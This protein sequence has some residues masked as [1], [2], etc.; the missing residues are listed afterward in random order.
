MRDKRV[1]KMSAIRKAATLRELGR[2]ALALVTLALLTGGSLWL[3]FPL[4]TT[5]F[6][7]L[8]VI[9]LVS[10]AGSFITSVAL[11]LFAVGCLDFFFTA[12]VYSFRIDDPQQA[13]RIAAFFVTSLVIAGLVKRVDARRAE[14]AD[15]ARELNERDAKIKRL[16]DSNIVGIFTWQLE[17][18][19]IRGPILEAN[20]AFLRM[21]GYAR[22]DFF[23]RRLSRMEL[24]PPEW[25]A[26]SEQAMAELWATGAFQLYEKEYFRKD[27]GRVPVLV[28]A[29]LFEGAEKQGMAF[30]LDLTERKRVERAL[31]ESEERFRVLSESSVTGIYLIQDGLF[32][33]INPAAAKM[34]GYTVEEL[35]D[36]LGP[37]DVVCPEDRIR[38]AENFR[39]RSERE[40]Q[41]VRHAFRGL[42]KDG[43][44]FPVEVHGRWIDH[45]GKMAVIGTITD[46][47]ERWKAEQ[48][49][50]ESEAKLERA[51]E[52]AHFGW[53]E[54]DLKTKRV[55]LSD[56]V[57]RIFGLRPVD[58]PEWHGRW[59]TLI[60]PEDR[61]RAEKAAAAAL[62]P[63]GPR[64]DVEYRVVRRDGTE[65][66][67]HSQGDVTWDENGQPLRQFGVLQDITD[68]RRAEDE[69]R[70]SEER[71]RTIV[72]YAS[73]AFFVFDGNSTVLDVNREA[74][75]SLGY[76][77]E[78]L[79][80][81]HRSDF[82]AAL[83]E[84][85]IQRLKHRLVSGEPITFE[86]RH[87]RKDGTTFP[88]EVRV[89]DF[90]QGGER[91]FLCLVRDITERKRAEERLRRNETYLAAA[92][93]LSKMGS[94][95]WRPA[96]NEITHWSQG[97]YRLFG[98]DPADGVP[99]LE[100]VLDRI[101]PE[102]RALWLESRSLVA[103][104]E[105]SDFD[106]RIVLPDGGTKHVHAVG[107]PILNESGEVVEVMGAAADIS[108][109]KRAE[110]ELRES[111]ARFRSFVDHASDGFFLFDEGQ[112]LID[113][114][115][116]AC[117]SLGYTRDE[118]IGMHPGEFD[119]GLDAAAIVRIGERVKA[120]ETVTFETVHRR[121]DGTSFPVEI[122][123][124]QFQLGAHKFRLSLARDITERK[125]A[126]EALRRSETY[127]AEAQRLSRIGT[128]AFNKT[129]TLYW[130]EETYR[131]AGLD[132]R[133]GLPSREVVR[134]LYH[135]DD[136]D[137]V[138]AELNLAIA[139]K[140]TFASEFRIVLPDSTVKYL[141]ANGRPMFSARGE[142]IEVIGSTIDVT[143]RKRAQQEHERLRQLEADLA[144]VNRLSI[145][146]E[147]AASLAHEILHPIAT[148]RNNA[149]AAIRFLDKSPP[150][151][152][153]V[154]GALENIVRDADRGKAIVDR[155][156]DH[157]K[158]STPRNDR[159][160]L[161]AA[162]REVI[163]MARAAIEQNQVSV[164]TRLAPELM[165]V[166]GDRV[167]LQQVVMNLVMNGAE[168][169]AA[170]EKGQ[171]NL[172]ITTGQNEAGGVLVAVHD[173]GPGIDPEHLEQV[174]KPFYTTKGSGVGMG[175]AI[176]RSIIDAH[177]GR[178]WA[179]ANQPCGAVF[180]FTLPV[181]QEDL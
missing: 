167:Q 169:M 142:F 112:A 141:Q 110:N 133:Q 126:E 7:Y 72:D 86:T 76:S 82:D 104:G 108:E 61:P 66:V 42:R 6:A 178:L 179:E 105:E 177:G 129:A 111:E 92:E 140:K 176:C 102:D 132:P 23:A 62:L 20:D 125:R 90:Q 168:A 159:F 45:N 98:F 59:L 19:S 135:P 63:G 94:W 52:V 13:I 65:R 48:E 46:N 78:E 145:M 29:A 28:G 161:N 40:V 22:D 180:Q 56:E 31:R 89:G 38:V 79:I 156:R 97:R 106:F 25:V 148:A 10:L 26:R 77:R 83:D 68:L 36:R 51:Q 57:C 35:V 70:T 11:S 17:D 151:M 109:R 103:R 87:R 116:Q 158:K 175:L 16:V 171:R 122:R 166:W 21:V 131:I 120:G 49:L 144:H 88:V 27:G 170:V 15:L 113:V 172:L 67:V 153:E 95:A 84:G 93:S 69:L 4:A 128:W 165:P 96:A 33:Y 181:T 134:R 117:E 5:A 136:L 154:R 32:R 173:S 74:C 157:V 18:A 162:V 75:R 53:W 174:F 8:I 71:F 123:A 150:N 114:N 54:R 152:V 138:D 155:M 50:R 12:P 55:T 115:R 121:K 164:R 30:V 44:T 47:T 137:R 119:A 3:D 34:F 1:S 160:D 64:Y 127:L 60:H 37:N 124:R 107:R 24:T 100:A 147:L 146:G 9:A 2:L 101:H 80:G 14:L 139:E 118:M 41:E 130:S 163:E 143:E 43:S 58:L 39:R 81:R 149:R 91:R 85:S 99:S 73:D